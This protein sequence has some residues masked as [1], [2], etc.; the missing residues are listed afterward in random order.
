MI[1]KKIVFSDYDGTLYI[2]EN[3]MKKNVESIE[4]YRK[5]GGL[6]VIT[7]GRSKE[8][9]DK[10]IKKY[11][12][13]YDYIILNNGAIILN[14]NGIKIW[15]QFIE[16]S[17]SLKIMK[18]LENKS[19]IEVLYYTDRDKIKYDNQKLLKI[20]V[21]TLN[22]ERTKE[23]E[24]EINYLFGTQVIAFANFEAN[25]YDYINYEHV[26]IVSIK[27]GKEK[28]I[29]E[30]L[31]LLN[32]K[33]EEV[34]TV[35]DGNNDIEMIKQYNGYSMETADEN[36]KKIASKVFHNISEVIEYIND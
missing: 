35:G 25:S 6:F 17:V 26:D 4:K 20:R 34:V 3:E 1:K 14:N 16:P 28:G 8:S 21:I 2:K 33:K 11:N 32:I 29:R 19:D 15:E 27:A 31:E 18:Y 9:I 13:E 24:K 5:N 36:V 10:V 30:L 22:R 23:I 7:T 12:I